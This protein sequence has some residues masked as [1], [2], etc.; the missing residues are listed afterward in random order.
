MSAFRS[1][2]ALVA[3][4]LAVSTLATQGPAGAADDRWSPLQQ[5]T[6]STLA[7]ALD[8]G[9]TALVSTGGP[10][11]ATVYDQR[12]TS[13]GTSGPA[14][15]IM[16]VDDAEF[17]RPV[18]AVTALG[19]F[20]VAVECQA[21]TG[22]EDPPTVLAELVW[23][24]DDG[25]VW[26][27]LPEGE[28]GSLD[29]SAQG[30]FVLFTSNSRYGRAHHLTSY[31]P[32]L[33]W[34][35]LTRREHRLTG[36]T[37]VAAITDSGNVVALRGAGSEDEPGYWFGGLL[38]IETY[39]DATRT[40]TTR[41]DRVYRDGGIRPFGVDLVRGHVMATVV[42]SRSTGQL[43]ARDA[44]VVLLS[45]R[46][47]GPRTWHTRWGHGIL[48]GQA[49][50]T[51]SGVGAA[52]WQ[53]VDGRRSATPWF[54]T[55]APQRRQPTVHDLGWRTN[56]TDAADV[57]QALDL[58]VSANGHGT[59]AYVRHRPGVDHASVAGVSFRVDDRGDV[60]DQVDVTWQQPVRTTVHAT[61]G[62]SSSSVTLG[63]MKAP[64]Y[65]STLT[66]Y[67]VLP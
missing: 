4:A 16:T 1:P 10:D 60:R 13:A 64:S 50:I 30:Q 53:Q 48:A 36:D 22:L 19:N 46:P 44:R 67:S 47:D 66:R 27:V 18:E 40:W 3:L 55:W 26:K 12:R 2:S 15:P 54:A 37:M 28:L 56:L 59:I 58:A 61:A 41:Y 14:T 42:E 65:P 49:A 43:D 62:A 39:S 23:T 51:R 7:V 45:G 32:D 9:T 11:D 34:R 25:W 6:G 24:G 8:S 33:G 5:A 52:A 35:D 29:Y 20:A 38:R 21:K 57:G 31:H 63:L 17:C